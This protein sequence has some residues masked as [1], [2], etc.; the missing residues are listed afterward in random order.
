M[1]PAE[2]QAMVSFMR[3]SAITEQRP[4]IR[5]VT[6]ASLRATVGV[7]TQRPRT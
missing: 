1:F 6:L 5:D 3:D 7:V 2:V 4:H